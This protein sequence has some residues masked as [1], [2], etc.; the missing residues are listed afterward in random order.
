MKATMTVSPRVS[1]T[2]RKWNIATVANWMRERASTLMQSPFHTDRKKSA[3]PNYG[4]SIA[5]ERL[6]FQPN[7]S[8]T[9]FSMESDSR[10]LRERGKSAR[11]H[12][13]FTVALGE[14]SGI[15]LI[16]QTAL[17]VAIG[18]GAIIERPELRALVP[19]FAVLLAVFALRFLSD[20]AREALGL[21]MRLGR[22]KGRARRIDRGT[23]EHRPHRARRG[24]T[25]GRSPSSSSARSSPSTAT[26]RAISLSGPSRASCPS[27]CSPPSFPST[28]SRASSSSS[29]PCSCR[30]A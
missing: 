29:R 5:Q 21:R 14:L 27:P 7:F 28:G 16:L 26:T 17:L 3:G 8:Y 11:R 1:G 9:S 12:L 23:A 10:W 13:L 30:S 2:N 4:P 19:F 6:P 24:C 25:R 15:L 18:N 20:L 22:E